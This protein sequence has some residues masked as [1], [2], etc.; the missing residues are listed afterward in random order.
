MIV[1]MAVN[2]QRIHIGKH[3]DEL[4]LHLCLYLFFQFL[5]F[6]CKGQQQHFE[7][8]NGK[9]PPLIHQPGNL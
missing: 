3:P 5:L 2:A 7:K 9:H 4:R 6:S 8:R 1:L